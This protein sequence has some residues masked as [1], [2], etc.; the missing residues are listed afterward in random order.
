[1]CVDGSTQVG[2][3]TSGYAW[4]ASGEFCEVNNACSPP[5]TTTVATTT[6]EPTQ[7]PNS[8]RYVAIPL[9]FKNVTTD[10]E[11]ERAYFYPKVLTSTSCTTFQCD[12]I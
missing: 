8:G 9:I 4:N 3:C 1:M 7:S 11:I 12:I 5:V 10:V 2:Y 6:A